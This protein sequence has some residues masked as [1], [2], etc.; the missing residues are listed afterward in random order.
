MA[1]Y[2]NGNP[3]SGLNSVPRLT[4]AQYNALNVKPEFWIR[5]DAPESYK[6]LSADQVSYDSNNTVKDK[7]DEV[8]NKE[9]TLI[10]TI[11]VTTTETEVNI[12]D[13]SGYKELLF[14]IQSNADIRGSLLIPVS[15][16]DDGRYNY[17]P[18]I[19]GT[20][21]YAIIRYISNT[22]VSVTTGVSAYNYIAIYGK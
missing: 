8:D 1:L 17:L 7:I 16:F 3:V 20:M 5:T 14:Y 12:P 10:D 19:G 18:A 15:K 9:W 22:K 13:I 2:N 21:S 6:K 4:L 11:S